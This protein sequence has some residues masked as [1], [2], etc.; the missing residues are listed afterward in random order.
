[1]ISFGVAGLWRC[2]DGSDAHGALS[3]AAQIA[4]SEAG[5]TKA[6]HYHEHDR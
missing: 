6:G 1:M 5:V 2:Y 4:C 3:R